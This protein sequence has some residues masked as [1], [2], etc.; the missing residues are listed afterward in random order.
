MN[1]TPLVGADIIRP[2]FPGPSSCQRTRRRQSGGGTR[3]S[4]RRFRRFRRID[5]SFSLAAI[6]PSHASTVP[7][8]FQ[9]HRRFRRIDASFS[10]T[11]LFSAYSR[12]RCTQ[13][14]IIPCPYSDYPFPLPMIFLPSIEKKRIFPLLRGETVCK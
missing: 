4:V 5:A 9:T 13:Y 1:D 7:R 3:R 12:V 8:T 6:F 10:L 11:I 2:P 14:A